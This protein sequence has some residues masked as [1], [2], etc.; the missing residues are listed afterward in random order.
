MCLRKREIERTHQCASNHRKR[1]PGPPRSLFSA[2]PSGNYFCFGF[3]FIL[4]GF[5]VVCTWTQLAWT[6]PSIQIRLIPA[7]ATGGA[8][9]RT[10]AFLPP[11]VP[12]PL[13]RDKENLS[14]RSSSRG[15]YEYR[16]GYDNSQSSPNEL[17]K[18]AKTK[19]RSKGGCTC[20]GGYQTQ[21][22]QRV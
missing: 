21:P 14:F 5:P 11:P 2:F 16:R 15:L 17:T 8:R 19:T 20:V 13:H 22:F 12:D 7:Q 18:Q 4:S 3:L 6:S 1:L 10:S 9:N